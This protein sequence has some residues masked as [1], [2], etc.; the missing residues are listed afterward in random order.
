[1]TI[2]LYTDN[3]MPGASGREV[4][5]ETSEMITK[6]V[7]SSGNISIEVL[8]EIQDLTIAMSCPK[9]VSMET[10][11]GVITFFF[12]GTETYSS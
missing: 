12:S 10:M 11:R 7:I 2:Y 9:P 4:I 6:A 8:Q 3:E 1:M 5:Q